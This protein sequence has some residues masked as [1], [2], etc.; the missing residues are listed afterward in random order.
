MSSFG[1]TVKLTGESEY[2]KALSEIS[3]NLKVL[4]SEMKAVTSQY[5]KNDSSIQNFL[6]GVHLSSHFKTWEISHYS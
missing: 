1:G 5:D 6:V 3:G 2:R 4:N